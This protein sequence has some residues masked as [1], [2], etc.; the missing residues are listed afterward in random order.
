LFAHSD[1]S[2]PDRS[3]AVLFRRPAILILERAQPLRLIELEAA[4]LA[5]PFLKRLSGNHVAPN[6]LAGLSAR[7]ALLQNRD[8][9]FVRKAALAHRS[10]DSEDRQE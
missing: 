6:E 1:Q 3:R 7:R 8:D 4:V 10:S 5:A 9:L 2:I